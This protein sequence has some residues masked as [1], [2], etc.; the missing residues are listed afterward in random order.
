MRVFALIWILLLINAA[1]FSSESEP[2]SYPEPVLHQAHGML[3]NSQWLV[4]PLMSGIA[5]GI[6]ASN[7]AG[8][9][10]YSVSAG[11]IS[12]VGLSSLDLLYNHLNTSASYYMSAGVMGAATMSNTPMPSSINY[13]CGFIGGALAATGQFNFLEKYLSAPAKGAINGAILGGMPGAAAGAAL[14]AVD[15]VMAACNLTGTEPLSTTLSAVTQLKI[16]TPFFSSAASRL[17][18]IGS[19]YSSAVSQLNVPYLIESAGIVWSGTCLFT[20]LSEDERSLSYLCITL[21]PSGRA[22]DK[23]NLEVVAEMDYILN[24]IMDRQTIQRLSHMQ[25]LAIAGSQLMSSRLAKMHSSRFQTIQESLSN[26]NPR[27]GLQ[28]EEALSSY[29]GAGLSL[30]YFC[31]PYMG[32]W[33]MDSVI[34]SY[35]RILMMQAAQDELEKLFFDDQN[36]IRLNMDKNLDT[37]IAGM[38]VS[39][40]NVVNGGSVLKRSLARAYIGGFYDLSF[41]IKSGAA[42]MLVFMDIYSKT[43]ESITLSLNK[44]SLDLERERLSL[45]TEL[46]LLKKDFTTN[47]RTIGSGAKKDFMVE[48][49]S[50]LLLA[51]R[52][53]EASQSQA[54]LIAGSWY[55]GKGLADF[56]AKSLFIAKKM[57]T[58]EVAYD[59]YQ[60]LLFASDSVSDAYS[61]HANN[62]D[63]LLSFRQAVY[64]IYSLGTE[65]YNPPKALSKQPDYQ[66]QKGNEIAIHLEAFSMGHPKGVLMTDQALT[67]PRGYYAVSGASGSGKSSLLSK[68]RREAGNGIWATGNVTYTTAN[69]ELPE[70]FHAEQLTYLPPSTTLRELVT[71]RL[72]KGSD[73]QPPA[74]QH[75]LHPKHRADLTDQELI[76]LLKEIDFCPEKQWHLLKEQ[77]RD[78]RNWKD[79]LSGGQIKKLALLSMINRRPE[80]AILDEIFAGMDPAS[81]QRTQEMLKKYL[82]DSLLL[83]V[84]HNA[85]QNN[86]HGFYSGRVHLED[87][88][89]SLRKMENE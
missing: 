68:I 84:D 35:Y 3:H 81:V 9:T 74:S 54:G 67:I 21:K 46:D 8:H 28:P 18:M 61:W 44:G 82:P 24:N 7:S 55:R 6:A 12:G 86:Y 47:A 48:K 34:N 19:S 33:L 57:S 89:V 85:A 39:I 66:A 32:Q 25:A 37:L 87:S 70:V 36:F 27:L 49:Y 79:Q 56:L 59:D 10:P 45:S 62:V 31:L 43:T 2:P 88:Q 5:G 16:M 30:G 71:L 60:A 14:G 29:M 41:I 20:S 83:I 1:A 4:M 73:N 40:H 64:S 80:V 77:L 51:L 11:V 50:Q 23:S 53:T 26:F 69:G 72:E 75:P 22:N 42:D 78:E 63:T 17:P 13:L 58:G 15:E 76:D 52:K 38:D 65:I